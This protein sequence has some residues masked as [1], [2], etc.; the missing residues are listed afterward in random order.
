M[1]TMKG[2]ARGKRDYILSEKLKK[3]S[4]RLGFMVEERKWKQI[5]VDGELG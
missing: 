5:K 2:L 4:E 1:K 3:P